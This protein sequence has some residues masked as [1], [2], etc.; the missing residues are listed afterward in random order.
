MCRRGRR[1]RPEKVTGRRE[2]LR[3][4]PLRLIEKAKTAKLRPPGGLTWRSQL[5][6]FAAT[7]GSQISCGR[8]WLQT[9]R[10]QALPKSFTCDPGTGFKFDWRRRPA[11]QR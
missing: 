6:V 8:K 3:V 1:H 9:S 2:E 10:A 4:G 11:R 7:P 5:L